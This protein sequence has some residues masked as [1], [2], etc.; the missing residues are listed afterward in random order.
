MIPFRVFA[1][2]MIVFIMWNNPCIAMERKKNSKSRSDAQLESQALSKS[3]EI[4]EQKEEKKEPKSQEDAWY[5]HDETFKLSKTSLR[6]VR[7]YSD[8][9]TDVI[10]PTRKTPPFVA[11]FTAYH[12][13]A[14]LTTKK[15]S[16]KKSFDPKAQIEIIR[17]HHANIQRQ[18]KYLEWCL[19]ECKATQTALD[20]DR[21]KLDKNVQKVHDSIVIELNNLDAQS[22]RTMDLMGESS[23]EAQNVSSYAQDA[24]GIGDYLPSLGQL[25]EV[26]RLGNIVG[27][28]ASVAG[29]FV[30]K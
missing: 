22:R 9:T 29:Y 28:A 18:K 24:S 13:M 20:D 11:T 16:E 15:S 19:R 5:V 25:G 8:L 17:A 4:G 7:S 14:Q 1:S 30:S 2:M 23:S 26:V 27:A 6:R 3:G 10:N 12:A 21:R